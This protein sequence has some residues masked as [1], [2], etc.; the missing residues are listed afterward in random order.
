MRSGVAVNHM[1]RREIDDT[2]L[3]MIRK[4]KPIKHRGLTVISGFKIP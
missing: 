2:D 3:L 1:S 4:R